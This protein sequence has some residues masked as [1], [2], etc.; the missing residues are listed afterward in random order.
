RS[1]VSH[2]PQ[3]FTRYHFSYVPAHE[4]ENL[5]ADTEILASNLVRRIPSIR[6]VAILLGADQYVVIRPHLVHLDVF[7]GE[8]VFGIHFL[9]RYSVYNWP[10]ELY[11][12]FSDSSGPFAYSGNNHQL[13][14]LN[15]GQRIL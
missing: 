10:A 8:F 9:R 2:V 12:Q 14:P 7:Q 6:S 1:V 11:P 4:L 3:F 15:G 5:I 13:I